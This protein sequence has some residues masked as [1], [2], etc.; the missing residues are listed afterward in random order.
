MTKHYKRTTCRLCTSKNLVKALT[1]QPTPL[2]DSYLPDPERA[3]A[4]PV[5]PLDLFL[6]A[7]CG[8]AQLLDV[9]MPEEIYL[10]YLYE[11]K[12]SL[13]LRNHF[14]QY[15]HDALERFASAPGGLVLDIGSNDG[16]LL[17]FFAQGG[18]R[19]LGIDP[20]TSIAQQATSNGIPTL[21]AFFGP[22]LAGTIKVEYGPASIVTANNLVANIDNLHDF[23]DGVRGVLAKDGVFIFESFYMLDWM[24]NL[25]FDFTYHEHLSYF[26]VA[27][28]RRFFAQQGMELF[29]VLHSQSK[30]GSLRYMVQLAGGGRPVS[31]RVAEQESLEKQHR[32]H[33]LQGF[34]DYERCIDAAGDKVR[35]LLSQLRGRGERIVG[36]GASA[37]TTT[38]LH[39]FGLA[40]YLDY[41]VDEN[42][43]KIG[44]YAPGSG[45]A[46]KSLKELA[47]D[48]PEHI[49]V[50]AW[51][52]AD[53]IIAKNSAHLASGGSFIVPL[54]RLRHI[55]QASMS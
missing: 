8:H 43:A 40:Q 27:P 50:I 37:T 11:T 44:L 30:G 14:E 10:D 45:L 29:D 20:A 54:P 26:S 49:L 17:A 16:T 47:K 36:Y 5:F 31:P 55:S 52:Y 21:A 12:S 38:F 48:R 4:L 7:E 19:V 25:V 53:P 33:E 23:V 15:A 32:L 24:R 13:G 22:E 35:D 6:C 1:L 42:L 18:M 46:V 28:L 41:L 51:R 39:H 9:V 34:R 3:R 2:A